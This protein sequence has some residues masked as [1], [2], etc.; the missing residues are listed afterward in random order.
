VKLAVNL[1]ANGR[2]YREGDDVDEALL[3][4]SLRKLNS[5]YA[6]KIRRDREGM[7]VGTSQRPTSARAKPANPNQRYVRRKSA[8]VPV[9]DSTKLE[10]GE[11]LY[12][13][14]KGVNPPRFV[15]VGHVPKG[16]NAV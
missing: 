14:E 13:R 12:V 1:I 16:A 3:P 2:Y 11:K 10:P 8:F 9:S 15:R 5:G 6:A 7:D 4:L